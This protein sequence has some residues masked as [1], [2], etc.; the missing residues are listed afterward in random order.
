M[1]G[2]RPTQAMLD[3]INEELDRGCKAFARLI[4]KYPNFRLHM[5]MAQLGAAVANVDMMGGDV[6]GFV[7]HLREREPK[8][9]PLVPPK[10]N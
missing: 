9:A 1:S 6:E 4:T 7:A 10:G 5:A 2:D 8:P 3:E